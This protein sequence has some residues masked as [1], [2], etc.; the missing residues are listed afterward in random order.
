MAVFTIS[1]ETPAGMAKLIGYARISTR[2]R[3][4]DRQ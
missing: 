2:Q 3:S 1:Y 4:A